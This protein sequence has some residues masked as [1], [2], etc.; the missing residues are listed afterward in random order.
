MVAAAG[1]VEHR[2]PL[3]PTVDPGAA[4]VVTSPPTTPGP[5]RW[6]AGSGGGERER[7]ERRPLR[8]IADREE[9]GTAQEVRP[10]A[11]AGIGRRDDP[12]VRQGPVPRDRDGFPR[13]GA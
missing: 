5:D 13:L 1:G 8:W 4:S 6:R 12:Q 9:R 10:R 3:S 7:R 11:G 2:Q